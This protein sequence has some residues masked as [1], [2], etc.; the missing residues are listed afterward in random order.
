[1]IETDSATRETAPFDDEH[2]IREC[3]QGSQ[4]AWCT[5]IDKYRNLIFSI[6]V[7]LGFSRDDASDVFQ[8]VCLTLLSELPRIREPKTLAAWL[9]QVTAHE[10]FRWKRKNAVRTAIKL[11]ASGRSLSRYDDKLP[12]AML[13]ELMREQ[14]LREAISTLAPRCRELIQHLFFSVPPPSY[15]TLATALGLATGSIGFIRMRCLGRL[16]RDLEQRGF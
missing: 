7:K 2:L 16:R 6:P 5:L 10:C 11:D 1:M 3:V 14:I 9:I 8:N 13:E 12:D 4:S 15:E